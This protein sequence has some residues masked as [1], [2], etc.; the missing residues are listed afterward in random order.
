ME[1]RALVTGASEGIGF[2][3]AK[4]L[5]AE[6]YEVTAVA[7]T[8]AKLKALVE[9]LGGKHAYL[10]AD[11][12][13]ETGQKI[14]AEKLKE[15]GYDLLVNNAGV[16][17]V[18][19]FTQVPLEKQRKMIRLNVEALMT[20]SYA[21]L[22]GAKSGD[23]LINVSSTLAFMPM[24]MIGLYSATK[25]FVTSFT[26]S[27]WY[28]NKSKGIYVMGLCPGITSTNFQLNAGGRA[29]DVPES[30]AQTPDQVVDTA[31]K[32]LAARKNPTVISGMT[33]QIFASFARAL[34]RKSTV[35]LM[36]KM[37]KN[38]DTEK[39]TV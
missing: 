3:F 23:A 12:C 21:F 37:G 11:L 30:M 1:K 19:R 20:L 28:E 34:P 17:T 16:G 32:A 39:A 7:R 33:N 24:P 13:T 36:G 22:K 5:A 15:T 25:A 31:L 18:G 38:P 4:R 10:V 14:V 8:E 27:L 2:V 35:S 29:G 6:G 9:E 26:E